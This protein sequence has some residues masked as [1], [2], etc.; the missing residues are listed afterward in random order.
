VDIGWSAGRACIDGARRRSAFSLE[1][2]GELV[3]ARNSQTAF[4]L[5]RRYKVS[6][7]ETWAQPA[8]TGNRVFV[9]DVTS[10]TLWSWN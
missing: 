2:D 6:P 4:E 10:L 1:S 9:K 8:I 3:V 7:N 5:V